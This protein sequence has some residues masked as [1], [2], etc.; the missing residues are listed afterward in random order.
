[1][2]LQ[3]LSTSRVIYQIVSINFSRPEFFLV[4]NFLNT[5]KSDRGKGEERI[6]KAI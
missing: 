1:M 5:Q 6:F 2:K 4:K 3:I